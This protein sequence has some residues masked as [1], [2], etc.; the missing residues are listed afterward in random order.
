VVTPDNEAELRALLSKA[1]DLGKGVLH[2]LHPLDGLAAAMDGGGTG[3][4]HRR[5]EGLQHQARLPAMRHQLPRAGPAHVQLQQQ[6]RLV[7]HCVGTGLALTREQRKAL[8]DSVRDDDDK[9]RE[10]SFPSEEAEVEGL[11]DEPCPDCH[12]ARLNP[13][14]RGVTFEAAPSARSRACR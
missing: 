7:R 14:S 10:Q 12:G 13:A 4:G 11:A 2:L 5:G 6:A 8:D 3:L 1:L 9:G